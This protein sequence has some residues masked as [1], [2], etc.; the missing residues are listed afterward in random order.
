MLHH[1]KCFYISGPKVVSK[2]ID[3]KSIDI[4]SKVLKRKPVIWDNIHANDY[5]QRRVFLGPFKG[6]PMDLY[7]HTSGILTNPNCEFECNFI[8]IHSLSTWLRF[9]KLFSE[10][11]KCEDKHKE[12]NSNNISEEVSLLYDSNLA[13]YDAVDCWMELFQLS[14]D[15]IQGTRLHANKVSLDTNI[16]SLLTEELSKET[17]VNNNESND[18]DI[19]DKL[20][21]ID[22]ADINVLKDSKETAGINL[23][24]LACIT[25]KHELFSH[26]SQAGMHDYFALLFIFFEFLIITFC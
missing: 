13:L 11:N 14:R 15:T 25:L 1:N 17:V 9:A 23:S 10:E 2:T 8:A 3:T 4:L 5:D 26:C 6:R 18:I 7:E 19:D 22:T 24:N 20:M 16:N 12:E 21:G